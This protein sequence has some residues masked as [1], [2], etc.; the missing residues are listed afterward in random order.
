MA[1]EDQL[2]GLASST[3]Y[4][5]KLGALSLFSLSLTLGHLE[6]SWITLVW[7]KE[8]KASK[9]RKNKQGSR[10]GKKDQVASKGILASK[11]LYV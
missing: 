5:F 7:S 10:K 2:V 6:F 8:R 3:F 11:L 1:F 4:Q 9:E